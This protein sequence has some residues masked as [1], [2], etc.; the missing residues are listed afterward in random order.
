MNLDDIQ[1]AQT[2]FAKKGIDPTVAE[3]KVLDTYRSDHCRHTTFTTELKNVTFKQPNKETSE[4]ARAFIQ[5]ITDV[6]N[7]YESAR[8]EL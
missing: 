2:Y 7:E 1:F 5:E 4:D 8:K 6:Q 3:I